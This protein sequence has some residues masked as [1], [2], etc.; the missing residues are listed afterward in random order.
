MTRFILN[1][2]AIDDHADPARVVLDLIRQRQGLTGTKDVCR[3]GD[4]GACQVLLGKIR[5]G[6]LR[7]QAVNACLLPLGAIDACHVVTV[8][9][10]NAESLNPVQRALVDCGAIQCGFCT[11]GLVMALTGFF[12]NAETSD[13]QAAID[14]L[15]GNLCRCTGYAGIKR[16]IARLCRQF[17]LSV[18]PPECRIDDLVRWQ[19]L[20]AYFSEIA[21]KLAALAP[22]DAVEPSPDALLVGGGTDLWVARPHSLHIRPLA[23]LPD[24][25]DSVRFDADDCI[26]NAA[27]SIEQL[28]TSKLFR[29]LFPSVTQ[30]FELICSAPVRARATVGGNLVNASPIADLAVFF[31]ALNAR[32]L[33]VSHD[34]CRTVSL[35]DFFQGYKQ[36]DLQSG[37]RLQAIRFN[38]AAA[39]SFSYEKVGMRRHLDIAAVNSALGIEHT[40]GRIVSACLS[41]GGVAPVPFYFE[42]AC[43]Y[44]QGRPITPETVTA[45]ADIARQEIAPISDLRGS[46]DYKRLLLRQLIFAHFMKLF[47]EA[48][49]WE[50][51]HAR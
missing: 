15:A 22:R 7:Y 48:I 17:D 39:Q 13:E 5:G 33:L 35:K 45:A 26:V 18:S 37:E 16:A 38:R 29:Q 44:L 2:K 24:S 32:L 49:R 25:A 23:F 14:A 41:A 3:E 9:G 12:L 30:D 1:R 40:D 46:A 42:K 28:Q 19:I 47:P 8:E 51:L 11:P 43:D 50:Q 4:C 21:A 20:P 27:A 6:R 31:L 36:V 10:L 34:A